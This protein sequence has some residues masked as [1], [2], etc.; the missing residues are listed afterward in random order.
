MNP[1]GIDQTVHTPLWSSKNSREANNHSHL[2]L[3]HRTCSAL[4]R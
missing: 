1:A 3:Q 4:V 2:A